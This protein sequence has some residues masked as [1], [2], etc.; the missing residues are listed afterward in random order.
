MAA[1]LDIRSRPIAK[2]RVLYGLPK[3]S[4][5]E[6]PGVAWTA[7]KLKQ[8]R[9]SEVCQLSALPNELQVD[10]ALFEEL[11]ALHPEEKGVLK[12]F[13]REIATPRWEQSYGRSYFY[14]GMDHK[15]RPVP[16]AHLA[17]L[18]K[19]VQEH[20]GKEYNQLLV[21]W[22]ADGKDYIGPHS[23]NERQL[24]PASSIYSFSF[25][26]ERRFVVR[27]KHQ[28]EKYIISMPNNSL[29]V[30]KG[31][32]QTHYTHSVPKSDKCTQRRIN[33]TVRLFQ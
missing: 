12:V 8:G 29:L 13:G 10:E 4:E 2:R 18:L 15:A 24:V 32:M 25:G 28:K 21:N 6:A 26:A 20:S 1:A 33:V 14:A 9:G 19:W 30:M 23:D 5:E 7:L 17:R 16:H 31:D 22:Y 3:K 27:A 11:W